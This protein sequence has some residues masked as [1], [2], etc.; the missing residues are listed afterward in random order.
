MNLKYFF[1]NLIM[2]P[3]DFYSE[4]VNDA[5]KEMNLR[6]HTSKSKF[7]W[8]FGLPKSGTTL[9]EEILDQTAH[10]R[11]DRSS[12]RNF[13]N[14]NILNFSNLSTYTSCFPQNKYSY[15]KTHLAYDENII[16]DLTKKDFRII[17]T[18]RDL[19]DVMI[20]RYYHVMS[21]QKHWQHDQI[22]SLSFEE[23][24]IKSLHV[25]SKKEPKI[26]KFG[27]LVEYYY[28]IKNWKKTENRYNVIKIWYED[29]IKNPNFFIKEVLNF[30]EFSEINEVL[31][32]KKLDYRRRKE[33][34]TPLNEKIKRSNQRVST[35]RSGTINQWKL[36]FNNKIYKEFNNL[37]P[38][39][40]EDVL[41]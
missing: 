5:K 21:D 35:F 20:S 15:I 22:R 9:V 7:I 4:F 24:F 1:K 34:N 33:R 39:K 36:L 25:R 26:N 27:A 17:V 40:L 14:K 28:W 6:S 32:E 16:N 19:R 30:T 8:I 11:I 18:F 38:G 2:N 10:I 37:L 41:K 12:F 23:G 3:V 31:I 13:P 29:Y